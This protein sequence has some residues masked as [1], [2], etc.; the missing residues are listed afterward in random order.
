MISVGEG[1][2]SNQEGLYVSLVVEEDGVEDT[3]DGDGD[4]GGNRG[5]ESGFDRYRSVKSSRPKAEMGKV[6]Y[7]GIEVKN[8]IYLQQCAY[9][10]ICEIVG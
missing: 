2:G 10:P 3:V 7:T 6:E 5:V 8:G 9:A 4:G 1:G